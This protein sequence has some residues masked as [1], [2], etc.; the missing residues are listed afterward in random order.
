M[1]LCLHRVVLTNLL[2][3]YYSIQMLFVFVLVYLKNSFSSPWAQKLKLEPPVR[4]SDPKYGMHK[5][6]KVNVSIYIFFYT[7]LFNERQPVGD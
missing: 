2:T 4:L 5:Y 1:S 7:L 3:L 6:I